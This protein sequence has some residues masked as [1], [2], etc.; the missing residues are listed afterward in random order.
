MNVNNAVS[1]SIGS[2]SFEAV[3]SQPEPAATNSS[4][5]P[6]LGPLSVFLGQWSGPGFNTI[7]RPNSPVTPTVLPNNYGGSDNILQLNL[8]SET[9]TF[10][11][12]LG[13]VPNR[14]FLPG[15]ADIFLNGVP[16]LQAVNDVT[17]PGQ[18][19]GIHLEPGIW[20]FVPPTANPTEVQTV[21][22]MASIPHGT[23]ILA[24]GTC[25]TQVGPPSFAT[26]NITPIDGSTP[27]PFPS[28]QA[29][30][31]STARIPQTLPATITQAML[32][33]PNSVLQNAIAGQNILSTTTLSISTQPSPTL[34]GGGTDNI[35]FLQGNATGSTPNA[36]ATTMTATFW[37]ETVQTAS[38]S[39]FQQIQYSQ[40]VFLFFN[41]L[42]WPH[43]SVA[44]LTQTKPNVFIKTPNGTNFLTVTN[45]GGLSNPD[46]PIQS[47]SK[48]VGPNEQFTLQ[49]I[50]QSAGTCALQTANGQFVT[51]VAG[52]GNGDPSNSSAHPIH[53]DATAVGPWETLILVPQ[54]NGSYAIQTGTGCYLTATNGGGLTDTVLQTVQTTIGPNETLTIAAM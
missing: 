43:V 32:D 31:T 22:R 20:A 28:Q 40:T 33:N 35:A 37:L 18:S 13:S 51:V 44:T 46:A 25:T 54:A 16:Y 10:S 12:S 47:S 6:N 34:F 27:I 48:T 21:V 15:Q 52:G 36:Q 39:T 19:F 14:G 29:S 9:L 11:P 4:A 45:D 53:S 30:N 38:G 41:G 5:A 8:T 42:I 49:W 24:Q 7:F 26:A 23:T 50:D 2:F 17:T 1:M 3:P